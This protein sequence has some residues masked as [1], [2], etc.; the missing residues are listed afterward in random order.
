MSQKVLIP[1]F[2][3]MMAAS[4]LF[5]PALDARGGGGRGGGSRGGGGRAS[6]GGG[7]SLQRSP[8]MSRASNDRPA[9][10]RPAA[11]TR[12]TTRSIDT[13]SQR[14]SADGNFP[15]NQ[16]ANERVQTRSDVQNFLQERPGVS[17]SERASQGVSSRQGQLAQER[18]ARTL[19]ERQD[20]GQNVRREIAQDRVNSGS[21][22]NDGFWNQRDYL[23]SYY[24]PGRNLWQWGTAAGVA[25][26]LG[27]GIAPV[28]YDY[29]YGGDGYWSQ[30]VDSEPTQTY[31][32]TTQ[33]TQ[34]VAT[35]ESGGDE[36]MS[37]GVFG[38]SK[39]EDEATTPN[40]FMQLVLNKQG[41]ISG[42]FYNAT[43]DQAYEVE[44]EVDKRTQRAAWKVV[45]STNAPFM[46]AGIYNLTQ[47]EAPAR[48]YF[49]N[50]TTQEM[51]LIRL[52]E[53]KAK[54]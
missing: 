29:S 44:G 2:I 46:E 4:L 36:W 50:G 13:A 25:G 45:G 10:T 22:F 51:L 52:K 5:I 27:W 42:T 37:L 9:A 38:L 48:V 47:S 31:S 35:Q 30:S 41:M 40:I 14:R 17:P 21:W 18:P 20:F 1:F 8:S 33:P 6:Q 34:S 23:P 12:P 39:E 28:Y 19:A 54:E 32:A 43:T 26:W 16:R 11:S 3:V 53:Q 24:T 49:P 7:R 15:Q